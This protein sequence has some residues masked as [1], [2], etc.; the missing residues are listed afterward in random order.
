MKI[1]GSP[2]VVRQVWSVLSSVLKSKSNAVK[3]KAA[4]AM[5]TKIVVLG[6]IK[7]KKVFAAISHKMNSLFG[8]EDSQGQ[9]SSDNNTSLTMYYASTPVDEMPCEA[10]QH[11]E[12]ELGRLSHAILESESSSGNPRN[13]LSAIESSR[14]STCSVEDEIDTLAEDFIKRFRSQM[15]LQKQN[16]FQRYREML[17][18]SV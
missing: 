9:Y 7:N 8:L 16:S 12:E 15:L 6:L 4:H 13:C 1:A 3:G 2:W 11:R 17:E 5:K 14:M 10:F 18:R